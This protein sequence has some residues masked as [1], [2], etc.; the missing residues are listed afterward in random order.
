MVQNPSAK[1]IF[2]AL[3]LCTKFLH[4]FRVPTESGKVVEFSLIFWNLIYKNF[5]YLSIL[6]LGNH[7]ITLADGK[8]M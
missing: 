5:Q 7:E 2:D 6:E 8:Q 1:A 3:V 4:F